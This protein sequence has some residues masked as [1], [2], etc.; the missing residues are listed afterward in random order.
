L[1]KAGLVETQ[2]SRPVIY[3]AIPIEQ[4][5]GNLLKRNSENQRE[6]RKKARELCHDVEYKNHLER[7]VKEDNTNIMIIHGKEN[8]LQKLK[9][10][11]KSIEKN[12]DVVTSATRFSSAIIEFNEAYKKALQRG[13][14]IHIAAE[15]N[16]AQKKA[17]DIVEALSKNPRFEV[18]YFEK[19]P[20]A[21]VTIV[22]N[23]EA[24][25]TMTSVAHLGKADALWSNETSFV[26]LARNFFID[27]WNKKPKE[28]SQPSS[29]TE[30]KMANRR[31]SSKID[32]RAS[33][34]ISI[35]R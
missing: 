11:F 2:I 24:F 19:T 27:Q 33:Q 1:E 13:V 3:K 25:M 26:A 6:I 14:A 12:L 4:A 34:L 31:K 30:I 18:R 28:I 8:I 7:D 23:K 9:D 32:R 10:S 35:S 29:Y 17:I 16:G 15:K 21:L 20:E 22:D 5:I